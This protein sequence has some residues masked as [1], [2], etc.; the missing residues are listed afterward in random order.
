MTGYY[1]SVEKVYDSLDEC[2][3][4]GLTGRTGSGCST[5]AGIL[6]TK[7]FKHLA[8]PAPKEQDY[9]DVEERK[10][11]VIHNYMKEKWSPF[12]TIEVSSIILSMV[13][14]KSYDDF[15]KYI[16]GLSENKENDNFSIRGYDELMKRLEGIKP[17]FDSKHAKYDDK[18][19]PE[20]E[21]DI[22][23]YYN[24]FVC[25]IKAQKKIFSNLLN[26]YSC[27]ESKK[28]GYEKQKDK[29]SQLYTFLLQSFGNNIRSSGNPFST[30]FEPCNFSKTAERV[31]DIVHL[32]KKYNTIIAKKES[33]DTK[34]R[35]CIDA[36]RNPYEAYYLK[37]KFS[38]FYLISV[39]T[40]DEERRARLTGFDKNELETL[41]D[42]EY[43]SDMEEGRIFYQQSIEECLQIAD[44]HLYN[45]HSDD[46]A[47]EVLT[48]NLVRYIALMIHPGI[49]TP[50]NIERC[51]QI[52]YTAKLNSG[53]LSRQVGSV[54]TDSGYYIKAIGW[55]EVPQ[56]QISCGL[57]TINNYLSYRDKNTYSKFELENPDFK[58][59]IKNVC[60]EYEKLGKCNSDCNM[61][62]YSISYC[63]KDIYN[64][65]KGDKNQVFTRSLHAE[66]NAF[67]QASKFGGQGIQG[68]KLFVTASPCELCSK[69]AYQLGIRD[70]YY[71]DPYPGIAGTHILKLG[72]KPTNPKMHI[73]YGAIGSA[74]VSMYSKRFSTKDELQMLSGVNMKKAAVKSKTEAD[75]HYN[76]YEYKQVVADLTF[77]NRYTIMF[78]I[79]SS[80]SPVSEPLKTYM[81]T[82]SWTGSGYEKTV[83]ADSDSSYD[84]S[85]EEIRDGI[86][87][88]NLKLK[89]ECPVGEDFKFRFLTYVKDDQEIMS[90]FLSYTVKA[91]TK[92]LKLRVKFKKDMYLKEVDNFRVVLY[93]DRKRD[94]V[95]KTIE[96]QKEKKDIVIR[97][98]NDYY[99][100]ETKEYLNPYLLY[101]Y[102][103]EWDWKNKK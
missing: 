100:V 20:S 84:I 55:N 83:A 53:C 16:K 8:L 71:I 4:I 82:I 22:E 88:I 77:D 18:N 21:S 5:A 61:D 74:Y 103:L 99:I 59:A 34:T 6:E 81:K 76:K 36:I 98:E 63:F 9:L 24:Y 29:K 56:G 62:K 31:Q 68:G 89:N 27:F 23:K 70:I 57:R 39:S 1:N 17:Y 40:E 15:M 94:I 91:K 35:I 38:S 33:S 52:A 50:T 26:D 30:E 60:N 79:E 32:I 97:K 93:A 90:P 11:A 14:Q 80:L 7:D 78:S 47:R 41:D 102:S 86:Y 67:L 66:E 12:V 43:P 10:D 95:Y 28:K 46:D 73:F 25:D 58:K 3:I 87:N 42:M 48:K 65:I 2:I 72:E 64:A 51:M 49:V 45:P 85:D 19:S 69:K 13:F 92:S 54:I 96:Y 37:D 101:T 44:I 75:D